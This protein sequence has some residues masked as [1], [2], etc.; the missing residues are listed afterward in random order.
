MKE[1]L[2]AGRPASAV[3]W[4][5]AAVVL[6]SLA[7]YSFARRPQAVWDGLVLVLGAVGCFAVAFSVA[8]EGPAARW[9]S[10]LAVAWE[11]IAERPWR[12]IA[13]LAAVTLL[14]YALHRLPQMAPRDDYTPVVVAWGLAFLFYVLAVAPPRPRPRQD[15]SIWWEVNRLNVLVLAA[16]VGVALLLRTWGLE[17]APATLSGDEA[18]FGREVMRVLRGELRNPFATGWLSQP[19]MGFFYVALFV[20][21]LG[22]SVVALRLPWA[23]VGT[24]TVLATFWL[25][26]RLKG[27]RL[28]MVTAALLATYHLH[29]HYSRLHLNNV[30]DPL[31]TALAL[32]LLMRALDRR[33]PLD[34]VLT[35]AATA[36]GLYVYTGGRLLILLVAAVVAYTWA[37]KGRRFWGE[38][39]TG[40]LVALGGFLVVAAPMLQFA[41]RFPDEFNGRINQ[42]GIIQSGWLSREVALRGQSVWAVLWDQFQRAALAFL[43][44]PDRSAFYGLSG[45]LL[46]PLFGS[47]FAVGLLYATFRLLS[48]N[49]DRRLFPMVAW[50]WG[51]VIFGGMLTESPP[52]SHRLVTLSV[53]VCFFV[54]LAL[55]RLALLAQRAL[56]IVPG[57]IVLATGVVVFGVMS[58]RMYF[59]QYIPSGVYGGPVAQLATQVAPTLRPL[60]ATHRFYVVAAPWF[61]WEFPTFPFLVPGARAINL[62]EPFREPPVGLVPEGQGAVFILVP[63]RAQELALIRRAYPNG[64]I[65]EVRLPPHGTVAAILYVVP[66]E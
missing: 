58:V 43:V 57:E 18:T 30:A 26:S 2:H 19:T 49:A 63:E 35:G 40:L 24:V 7:V 33:S 31:V 9:P 28:G 53:P 13:F 34:W 32:L 37:G 23:L 29:V 59:W 16:I 55:W 25:V 44:Y 42:V 65:K 15:W 41:L 48:P 27:V 45:P 8:R 64:Q 36:A 50:W 21:W 5:G 60:T 62:V 61:Y 54:A 12:G 47:L 4:L 11:G 52:S 56:E 46:D 3:V 14:A 51:G 20:R 17:R 38:Y 39:R 1:R 22:P 66:P 10:L 6:V